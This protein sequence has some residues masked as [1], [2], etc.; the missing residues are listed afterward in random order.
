MMSPVPDEI[1]FCYGVWHKGYAEMQ[2][3][4]V[5]FIEGM[6]DITEWDTEKRRLMTLFS[7]YSQTSSKHPANNRLG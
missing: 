3:R 1:I 4:G 5:K 2:C 6:P 7:I